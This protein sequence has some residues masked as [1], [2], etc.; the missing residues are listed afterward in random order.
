MLFGDAL[1][2]GHGKKKR[3][4]VANVWVT[5]SSRQRALD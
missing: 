4:G 3:S 2:R 5:A 1:Y